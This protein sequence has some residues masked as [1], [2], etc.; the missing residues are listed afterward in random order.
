V[1]VSPFDGPNRI[2][3]KGS[4]GLPIFDF[5]FP[6]LLDRLEDAH[7][8]INRQSKSAIPPKLSALRLPRKLLDYQK[9][10]IRILRLS[11]NFTNS[12]RNLGG[13]CVFFGDRFNIVVLDLLLE[14]T[15]N[16]TLKLNPLTGRKKPP[17]RRDRGGC[18]ES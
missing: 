2:R 8:T 10:S 1:P 18:A 11:L 14:R 9:L 7:T 5:R 12:L 16:P 17:R 4:L 13:L 3:F 6:I 15:L